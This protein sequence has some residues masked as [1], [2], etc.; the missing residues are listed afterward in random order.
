MIFRRAPAKRLAGCVGGLG[1]HA[2]Q[3]QHCTRLEI[4]L[5]LVSGRDRSVVTKALEWVRRRPHVTVAAQ[6]R[7]RPA[8]G[9]HWAAQ[10][11]VPN[12][13]TSPPLAHLDAADVRWYPKAPAARAGLFYGDLRP[14]AACAR[15]N[16]KHRAPP[17]AD[18]FLSSAA[19]HHAPST[20]TTPR[21][22][23]CVTSPSPAVTQPARLCCTCCPT[24]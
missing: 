9:G 20:T 15:R 1:L 19:A 23:S 5:A 16:K 21:S 6:G 13:A 14:R 8:A 22:R 2:G 11:L 3:P 4:L 24:D 17:L 18:T 12:G 10:Q 7:A